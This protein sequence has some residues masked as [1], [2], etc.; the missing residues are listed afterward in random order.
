MSKTPTLRGKSRTGSMNVA[1]FGRE[2][3]KLTGS[4]H[5]QRLE[6]MV[7]KLCKWPLCVHSILLVFSLLVSLSLSLNLPL[8]VPSVRIDLYIENC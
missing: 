7:S 3:A 6:T 2:S 8:F 1:M 5:A 4:H